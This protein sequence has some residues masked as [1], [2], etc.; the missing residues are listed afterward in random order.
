MQKIYHATKIIADAYAEQIV[1]ASPEVATW[2]F[3]KIKHSFGVAHDIMDIL[4]HERKIFDSF[5][6]DTRKL[7]EIA[8]IL[9]DLGR[10]YQHRD[11]HHVG[12]S[13][14]D[15]G[16]EAAKILE[17]NFPE[18]NNPILLFAIAEHNHFAINYQNP[19]FLQLSSEDKKIAEIIAKL[20]RDADKL[21]NIRVLVYFHNNQIGTHPQGKLSPKIKEDILASRCAGYKSISNATDIL[22][23]NMSWVHDIY[24]AST[25]RIIDDLG[26][27]PLCLQLAQEQKADD[28]DIDFLQKHFNIKDIVLAK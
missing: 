19:Y 28:E 20:V 25:L 27:I 14:Y 3:H 24:F 4:Y 8:A 12:D 26:F 1:N 7:T 2:L 10:F 11:G 21:E 9:H 13:V 17:K 18:F 22:T 23:A 15:H 5:S 16:V 6:D